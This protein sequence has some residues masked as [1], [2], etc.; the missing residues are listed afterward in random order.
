MQL[1]FSF[2]LKEK[3]KDFSFIKTPSIQTFFFSIF[4][5]I[6]STLAQ[7]LKI[8]LALQKL[9]SVISTKTILKKKS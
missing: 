5:F 2:S 4:L 9:R 3:N 8:A 7:G 6:Q 1:C